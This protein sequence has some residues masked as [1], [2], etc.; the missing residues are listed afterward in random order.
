MSTSCLRF[1]VAAKNPK[2]L[3]FNGDN[4]NKNKYAFK[5]LFIRTR[6]SVTQQ[7]GFK[8]R[9][10][11]YGEIDKCNTLLRINFFFLVMEI[12]IS[13]IFDKKKNALIIINFSIDSI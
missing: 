1:R 11:F 8:K 5:L 2:Q 6:T 4:K 10:L 12:T 7:W 3:I 9:L 13:T